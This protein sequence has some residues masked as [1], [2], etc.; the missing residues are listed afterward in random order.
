[1]ARKD[2]SGLARTLMVI[3]QEKGSRAVEVDPIQARIN[4]KGLII[5]SQ[6]VSRVAIGQQPIANVKGLLGRRIYGRLICSRTLP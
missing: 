1:M 2:I 4:G 5:G 6:R 3:Q